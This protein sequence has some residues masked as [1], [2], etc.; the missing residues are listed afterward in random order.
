MKNTNKSES[1]KLISAR[2]K[3]S[4]AADAR[5]LAKLET[6]LAR[7]A[8]ASAKS[9][10]SSAIDAE[11]EAINEEEQAVKA[12]DSIFIEEAKLKLANKGEV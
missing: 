12:L 2:Q 11:E 3:A 1:V 7:E 10:W 9:R 8:L 6:D 4:N 5:R